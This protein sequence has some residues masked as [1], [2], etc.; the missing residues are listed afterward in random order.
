[1]NI[2]KARVR[3][4]GFVDAQPLADLLNRIVDEG[5]KTAIDTRFDATEFRSWFVTGPHCL[6]CVVAESVDG[7]LLGFQACERY[8]DQELPE[9]CADIATFVTDK[10]RGS[11]IGQALLQQSLEEVASKG[12]SHLRAVIR[13]GNSQGIAYYT[14]SGF[15]PVSEV[16]PS[17]AQ[18]GSKKVVLA[19]KV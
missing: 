16:K 6:T 11:G 13:S 1:M 8:L 12:I 19:R 17:L 9:D 2:R 14:R 5:D 18:P 15:N 10:A 7:Q 4:V 3:R